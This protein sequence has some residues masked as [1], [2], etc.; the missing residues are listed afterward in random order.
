MLLLKPEGG[1]MTFHACDLDLDTMTFIYGIDLYTLKMYLHT[2]NQL[3]SSRLS[4]VGS[5]R[6]DIQTDPTENIYH[7]ASRVVKCENVKVIIVAYIISLINHKNYKNQTLNSGLVHFD[8]QA[9]CA[10]LH[11]F[12]AALTRDEYLL[13]SQTILRFVCYDLMRY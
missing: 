2:K 10:M 12:A 13:L 9:R 7:A 5:L 6:T 8:S 1:G 3:S 4:K 11:L